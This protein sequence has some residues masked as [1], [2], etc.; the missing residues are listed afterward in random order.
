[1]LRF[2]LAI[3]LLILLFLLSKSVSLEQ[4]TDVKSNLYHPV[5]MK[6]NDGDKRKLN[7]KVDIIVI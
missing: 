1:M 7:V 3:I 5:S 2:I 4:F 6:F